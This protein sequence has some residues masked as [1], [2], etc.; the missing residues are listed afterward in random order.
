MREI[1]TYSLQNKLISKYY[2]GISVLLKSRAI[3]ISTGGTPKLIIECFLI[4]AA[5]LTLLINKNTEGANSL[6]ITLFA[7]LKLL[8]YVQTM[9]GALNVLSGFEYS[10]KRIKN[11]LSLNG[12]EK[13]NFK[14]NICQEGKGII[15][16]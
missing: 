4:S 3:L 5:L 1:Y 9:Y 2:E 13:Q 8:P 16:T 7:L 11:E 12:L 14:K 15:S 10:L 6:V